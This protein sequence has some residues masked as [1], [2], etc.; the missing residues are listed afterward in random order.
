M[1]QYWDWIEDVANATGLGSLY[2][3]AR[4]AMS[5]LG[6]GSQFVLLQ[7]GEFSFCVTMAVH[8]ELS[9][10]T[11]YDWQSQR[12]LMRVPA[13][14]YIGEGDDSITLPGVIYC[15]YMGGV[16]QMDVIRA[17]AKKGDP[18]LL[19]DGMGQLLGEYCILS[20]SEKGTDF[21]ENGQPRKIEFS[22]NLGVYGDDSSG[23]DLEEVDVMKLMTEW[24]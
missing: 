14:Q 8:Q 6:L 2:D 22:V 17:M 1:T 20:V 23:S 10:N 7:L 9:R 21:D 12:R 24:S 3:Q 4:G 18:Y 11:D 13:R 19:I 15:E 16:G 5:A